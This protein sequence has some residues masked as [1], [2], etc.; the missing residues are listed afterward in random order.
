MVVVLDCSSDDCGL[1]IIEQNEHI[2][3]IGKQNFQCEKK[4]TQIEEV[5]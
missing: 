3:V 2:S 5:N 1:C 4:E